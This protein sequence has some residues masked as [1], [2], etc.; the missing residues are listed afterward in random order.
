MGP[1]Y[2]IQEAIDKATE[3]A[4]IKIN[5]GLYLENLVIKNKGLILEARESNSEVYIMGSKGPVIL[6]TQ[7]EN[8]PYKG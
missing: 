3:G 7:D 5:T 2:T 6:I 8:D 4:I 1:Y